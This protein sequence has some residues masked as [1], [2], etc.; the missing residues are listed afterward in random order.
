MSVVLA[1]LFRP[2]LIL[3]T[4]AA[5]LASSSI[6][7]QVAPRQRIVQ[8]IDNSRVTKLPGN[9][10]PLARAEFD[11]GR[12]PDSLAADR[13]LL[14]LSRTPEQEVA[15]AQLLDEQ[16]TQGAANY[17]R[18][19]TPEEFGQK[20]GT[21]DADIQT[22]TA[23]LQTQGFRV[24][25]VAASRNVI[26]FS[27]SARQ[28]RQ[29]FH[30][31]L[32]K[33][34]V[35]GKQYWANASDPTIPTALTSVVEGV[36]S[37]NNFPHRPQNRNFGVFTRNAEGLITPQVTMPD[38]NG[39]N[40][41]GVGPADFATI[42]KTNSLLS[43]GTNGTGQTIALIGETNINLQDVTDFRNLFSLGTGSTSV[44]IDGADP[45]IVNKGLETE[46]LLDVE[47]AS[48]VAPGA[49]V[50][51]VSAQSTTT[52][53][54]IYLAANYAIEQN[55]AS[56]LS[57]SFGSCEANLGTGGNGFVQALWQQAAAQGITVLV[58][59]GDEGSAGCDYHGSSKI[60][61]RGLGVNGLASTPYNVAVGG[62]DFDDANSFATYWSAT[63]NSTT[64]Q[65]A[66]SY[67]PEMTWNETCAATAR[68]GS[69]N[70][71]PT[72]DTSSTPPDGISVVA[73]SGGA[74]NC[75]T[76][77]ITS[78]QRVC[79]SGTAKP[80]WQNGAGVP[81]D[82]VRDLPDIS[83]FASGGGTSS[84]SFYI[85]CQADVLPSGYSS[86]QT[87]GG[88]YFLA[89]GG[90]SASA[91]SFAGIV[92][93]FNQKA[94]TRLGNI[95]YLL[96]S[97]AAKS[98][99]SCTSSGSEAA[100][101]IFNDVV[102][103]NISVPCLAGSPNCSQTTGTATGVLID[104]N[105]KPAFTT[106]ANY[107]LATGLGSV[108]AAN[109]ATAI[110]SAEAK[111]TATTTALTLN[112]ATSTVTARHGD[113]INIAV[114]VSP[115]SATGPVAVENGSGKGITNATLTSGSSTWTSSLFPGGNYAVKAHYAGD[116]TRA[117]SDSNAVQ[118][119]I[120]PEDSQ[121]FLEVMSWDDTS[122]FLGYNASSVP[123]GSSYVLRMAVGDAAATLSS[124]TGVNSKCLNGTASCPT[125]TVTLT[126]N[127]SPLDGGSFKLNSAGHAEDQSIDL[128]PG[129]YALAA[130][131]PGDASY[132]ASSAT[133]NLTVTKAPVN[134]TFSQ[135]T[136][137][138]LTYGSSAWFEVTVAATANGVAPTG[139]VTMAANGSSGNTYNLW[140]HYPQTASHAAY[141]TG[142]AYLQFLSVGDQSITVQ[143]SGDSLYNG[144][145][146]APV[147]V[148][149]AKATPNI[150]ATTSPNPTTTQ[151]PVQ[152]Q[153]GLSGT[154]SAPTGTITLLDNGTPLDANL[155]YQPH[156]S[157]VNVST[158]YTFTQTGAHVLTVN[159]PGDDHYT[160]LSGVQLGTIHVYTQVPTT[161][162]TP[163][164]N[165]SPALPNQAVT[166]GTSVSSGS[167]TVTSG[168]GPNPTGTVTFYDNG[169]P[170]S[171]QVSY[172]RP[173][174]SSLVAF[175][176]HTFTA[177]GTHNI[178]ASYSG[179][180]NTAA[181]SSASVA[182]NVMDKI[183][184]TAHLY[185]YTPVV[186][187]P[188]TINVYANP[189][190]MGSGSWP[191][192]TGTFT[193][194]ENGTPLNGTL[195][196]TPGNPTLYGTFAY[197]FTTTGTHNLKV[198]YSG[199]SNYTASESQVTGV[200]VLGVLGIT[201]PYDD[202]LYWSSA[203]GTNSFDL[204]VNNYG[205]NTETVTLTCTPDSSSATC[206]FQ[207]STLNIG[208][209]WSATSTLR[210]SVPALRAAAKPAAP[211]KSRFG[212]A[213]G[214]I[215]A[216]AV[217]LRRSKCR[218][219]ITTL[220]LLVTLMM[221]SCGGG[222]G[223]GSTPPPPTSKTYH[224]TLNATAG[225]NTATKVITV[226]VG[227]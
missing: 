96:Y 8:S 84:R 20:F 85:M 214:G 3:I 163:W 186:S 49:N 68:A 173:S 166:F 120:S 11:H 5:F 167:G 60:A 184:T 95:N 40:Y 144:T 66:K 149:V 155:T 136:Q 123:Y 74:S 114:N 32:H 152:I 164:A 199:D 29:S 64:F 14:L 104:S 180:N 217:L 216:C 87:S 41:Y 55:Q 176:T 175:V 36:V 106:T 160:A 67:I 12:A 133:A 129:T 107:D 51:L 61:T 105:Q 93:L 150:S 156:D 128:V 138:S 171:E 215:L 27:G 194:S 191:P 15:L 30:T 43:A 201:L 2:A 75:S 226:V 119:S 212:F 34:V 142:N 7:Q 70:T 203:G 140:Q 205:A 122:H 28:V 213:M 6:A 81:Q 33:Y 146:S 192:V 10:H 91:P 110:A 145:T 137:N 23:W 58:S 56:V 103:G 113:P 100:S 141:S 94:G 22:I 24:N 88:T 53:P 78:G 134:I 182:F 26:E 124:S 165:G 52:T 9:T 65:S 153:L 25:R 31:E 109:L 204:W 211:W 44:V 4:L 218:I 101:C 98:G 223:G 80:A 111:F 59:S 118:V 220:M 57:L 47:W 112:S 132:N 174:S 48:A 108:N 1:R 50:Q 71:C 21:A 219:A 183:S 16:Q 209:T 143:Y 157:W 83:L 151:L 115:T 19:L 139:T 102:K 159:Y 42:Y 130:S 82:G 69:L 37:L 116:G 178:T 117:A 195:T 162:Q 73:G 224:F 17:R 202:T 18:W 206:S 210:I 158:T 125:G 221:V 168:G 147:I 46:A 197:T 177:S 172:T 154:A 161:M 170:F 77:T 121:T 45:G 207:P 86:C 148:Q 169:T 35:G 92:A 189:Q 188:S 200:N 127:G 62:T 99:A 193:V 13:M 97:L 198:Q 225:T 208:S 190:I 39:G 38:G 131:Y 179:D 79:Q 54:G 196:T 222:G 185:S 76:S 135:T 72:Y 227:N 126:A 63:N 89:V 187:Q 181:S 90:T